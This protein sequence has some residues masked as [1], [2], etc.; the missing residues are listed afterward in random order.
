M[1]DTL[2]SPFEPKGGKKPEKPKVKVVKEQDDP[3]CT[4]ED[5]T[6]CKSCR[7]KNNRRLFI[8][9]F[10]GPFILAAILSS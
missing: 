9:V 10:I 3:I 6:C 8:L 7:E 4:E 2:R 5:H 1:T